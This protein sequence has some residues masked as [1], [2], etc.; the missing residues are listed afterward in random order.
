MKLAQYIARLG[1][2]SRR[3]VSYLFDKRRVTHVDG[4]TLKEK[5]DATHD[6]ILV[7]REIAS[8]TLVDD[9]SRRLRVANFSAVQVDPQ[10]CAVDRLPMLTA[11]CHEPH[12][13]QCVRQ[14][15]E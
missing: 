9:Q 7:D 15:V 1:Y 10:D 12:C 5:D 4:R 6:E 3:E 13:E 14:I 11:L 2:G 8:L